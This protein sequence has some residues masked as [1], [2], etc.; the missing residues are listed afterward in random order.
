MN[1][2]ENTMKRFN[3]IKKLTLRSNIYTI[4]LLTIIF[5]PNASAIEH[6]YETITL[7]TSEQ[8]LTDHA[9]ITPQNSMFA[10]VQFE[11]E[12]PGIF[13]YTDFLGNII[14]SQEVVPDIE[15][16]DLYYPVRMDT[17]II[18]SNSYG[19]VDE[20]NTFYVNAKNN[21]LDFGE[22]DLSLVTEKYGLSDGN[23]VEFFVT[24]VLSEI[25]VK[26]E[27]VGI[28]QIWINDITLWTIDIISP[29]GKMVTPEGGE[30]PD[31]SIIGDSMGKYFYFAAFEQGYYQIYLDTPNSYIRAR[32][33]YHAPK[34]IAFGSGYSEGVEPGSSEY[35]N[36][37]YTM[38]IYSFPIDY[39]NYYKYF[40]EIEYGNP[41]VKIFYE[42]REEY[43]SFNMVEGTSKIFNPKG[44]GR[45][46]IVFDNPGYFS[47]V[48]DGVTRPNPMKYTFK[49]DVIIPRIHEPG[50]SELVSVK[51]TDGFEARRIEIA[52]TSI[53][54]MQFE[55]KGIASPNIFG[56]APYL[57]KYFDGLVRSPGIYES[58]HSGAGKTF[59]NV[60]V[61]PGDYKIGFQ[62]SGTTGKEFINFN[63]SIT[64][65]ISSEINTINATD[66]LGENEFFNF[67]MQNWVNI[68]DTKG[69]YLGAGVEF[70]VDE[71]FRNYG[72]N[73]TLNPDE[74]PQIFDE[75]IDPDIAFLW[76][77]TS[78]TFT[79][80]T[81]DIQPGD[82]TLVPF[83]SSGSTVGDAFIIGSTQ[84]FDRMY[85]EITQNSDTDTFSIEYYDDDANDWVGFDYVDG[86]NGTNGLL[87]KTGIISWDPDTILDWGV[88]ERTSP[89]T[90]EEL[91]DTGDVPMYLIRFLCNDS[92]ASIPSIT[93][94]ELTKFV[95]IEIDLE[96][97]LGFDIKLFSETYFENIEGVADWNGKEIYSSKSSQSIQDESFSR[98]IN[99]FYEKGILFFSIE[100]AISYN[101]YGDSVGT[102]EKLLENLTF[103][104]GIFK[105]DDY[106]EHSFSLDALL[107]SNNTLDPN[108]ANPD[109]Y[110]SSYDFNATLNNLTYIKLSPNN[111][112]DWSYVEIS[113]E[114]GEMST[115][116]VFFPFHPTN[117]DIGTDAQFT[118]YPG[119]Q[120]TNASLEFGFVTD[121]VLIEIVMNSS[122][123][124]PSYNAT[125]H[126]S[127]GQF[128]HRQITFTPSSSIFIWE[129]SYTWGIIGGV[130]GVA[131][132]VTAGLIYRKKHKI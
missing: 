39:K 2:R 10:S 34:S 118:W 117:F 5:L 96:I 23:S 48:S 7:T 12:I 110:K 85:I 4:F 69:A 74:N 53:L 88:I 61:G 9:I 17:D 120:E 105:R 49:F 41:I 65:V 106:S 31:T 132:I 56:G 124:N 21:S 101:W 25:D 58:V 129:P 90:S 13:N 19:L 87:S 3:K 109:E 63:T 75:K 68:S 93:M 18:Y 113:V 125:V 52:Q 14:G 79:N 36:P 104:L 72:F 37:E 130:T 115:F 83:K 108:Y 127:G 15:D 35:L 57:Q 50:S 81:T 43:Q 16:S 32:C 66:V 102:E 24:E 26:V 70:D 112:Y 98:N 111:K 40:L 20:T 64:P 60:L 94:V 62:H 38:D 44:S 82:T 128:N 8:E 45:A 42:N 121:Y 71:N 29:S 122:T 28:Y 97:E 77:A 119:F 11:S 27:K 86:T 78:T 80:Y 103:S 114:N 33:E 6:K 91:P 123:L 59:Y 30:L 73:I 22:Y 95:K 54:S 51:I 84:K 107:L 99:F 126:I 55:D 76:D 46:Y 47:W 131:G 67:T 116:N 89:D 100:D 92:S 1:W